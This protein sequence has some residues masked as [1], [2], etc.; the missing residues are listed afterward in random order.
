VINAEFDGECLPRRQFVV[1][2]Q[3]PK[4]RGLLQTTDTEYK[5]GTSS[6]LV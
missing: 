2:Q 3:D 4:T 6:E 1:G 5:A